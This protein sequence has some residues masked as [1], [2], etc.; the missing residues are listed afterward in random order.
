MALISDMLG[1]VLGKDLTVL[2]H[3]DNR[4]THIFNKARVLRRCFSRLIL[5][6]QRFGGLLSWVW[7][8]NVFY[9]F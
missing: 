1:A 7:R 8:E 5:S 3:L 2:C 6:T 4:P 9:H